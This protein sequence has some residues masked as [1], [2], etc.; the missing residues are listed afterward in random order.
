MYWPDRGSGVADEPARR[1]VASLIRQYFTEGGLGVPPTVPGADWFNQITNEI[2]NVL[3]EAGIEPSKA[4][5]NQLLLAIKMVSSSVIALESLRRTYAEAGLILRPYPESFQK[6]GTLTGVD[7]VLLDL[8]TGKAFSGPLGHVNPGTDP[9]TPSFVDRSRDLLRNQLVSYPS[10][11]EYKNR[12]AD[13]LG[14]LLKLGIYGDSTAKG[15]PPFGSAG[16]TVPKPPSTILDET[17][18]AIYRPNNPTVTNHAI[19]GTNMNSMINGV[20]PY[21]QTFDA[22]MAASDEHI[23]FCNHAQNDCN[24]YAH[25]VDEFKENYIKFVE[26]CRK[27]GKVPVIVTPNTTCAVA[28][29]T[30]NANRRLDAFVDAMRDVAFSMSVD[31]VDNYYY[32]QQTAKFIPQIDLTPDGVHPTQEAYYIAGANMALPLISARTLT[33]AGQGAGLSACS[34]RDTLTNSRSLQPDAAYRFGEMLVA[35]ADSNP[36]Q[37]SVPIILDEPTVDNVLAF[38]VISWVDGGKMSATRFGSQTDASFSGELDLL[39]G[40]SVD[41]RG[42]VAPSVCNLFAGL[43]IVGVYTGP[44]APLGA[45]KMA[46]G[47]ISLISRMDR[48][49]AFSRHLDAVKY[50]ATGRNVM[51]GDTLSRT[52]EIGS[53]DQYLLQLSQLA[54]DTAPWLYVVKIGSDIVVNLYGAQTVVAAGIASGVYALEV[55]LNVDRTVKVVLGA[56]TVTTPAA[57]S[58]APLSYLSTYNRQLDYSAIISR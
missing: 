41:K 3:E 13:G 15:F 34:Y 54:N 40:L 37:I 25:N 12:L 6:G 55:T 1:P 46:L 29:I 20:A 26:I 8:N 58:G 27:H 24:S 38:E 35:T 10:C 9:A 52:V 11:A 57:S 30:E 28:G 44:G 7:D 32:F 2:L 49:E 50:S 51:I 5:D 4:D 36:Q 45:N 14:S 39:N 21:T 33:R 31:I 17:L 23:I 43:N 16:Q 47:G 18:Y 19:D 53:P 42:A 56:T 48:I 22:A